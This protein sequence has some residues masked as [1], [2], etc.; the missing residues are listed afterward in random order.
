M[1]INKM[2]TTLVA[3]SVLSLASVTSFAAP[4][5][6]PVQSA[7]T[8]N[9]AQIPA[10]SAPEKAGVVMDDT[11]ITANVKNQ[12]AMDPDVSSM[13]ISVVTTKGVVVLSGSVPNNAA[14][15]YLV[16]LV[17]NVEGVKSVENKMQ[18][19]TS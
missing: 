4:Q 19:K 18:L 13:K 8:Q 2:I 5:S 14:S 16:K 1:Q 17:S 9:S 11:M 10:P 15:T 12:L 6:A 3:T 7:P